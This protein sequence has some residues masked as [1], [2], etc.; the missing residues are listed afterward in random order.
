MD[1]A[2]KRRSQGRPGRVAYIDQANVLP[3]MVLLREIFFEVAAHFS[4]IETECV[5]VDAAGLRLVR[6]PWTFDVIVTRNTFGHI[7]SD[8][9][10]A[11]IGGIDMTP[12]AGIGDEHA[13]FQPCHGSA[14][15]IAG[16]GIA[17]PLAAILSVAM[18]LEHSAGRTDAARAIE[19]AVESVLESGIRTAELA[20]PGEKVSGTRE[21]AQAVCGALASQVSASNQPS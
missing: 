1:L 16:K 20:R 13:V 19:A 2:R 12:S 5:Y 8:V 21:V 11:L 15:D 10:A 7:L 14:P 6:E 18:L 17:N 4:D 3:A 9:G